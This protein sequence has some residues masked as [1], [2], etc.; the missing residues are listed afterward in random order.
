[1]VSIPSAANGTWSPFGRA[2]LAHAQMSSYDQWQWVHMQVGN[3]QIQS[4]HRF[5]GCTA[6]PQPAAHSGASS[7]RML[8]HSPWSFL[9]SLSGTDSWLKDI[10]AQKQG[11]S[12]KVDFFP[13]SFVYLLFEAMC[14]S[15]Y[16]ILGQKRCPE[17][18]QKC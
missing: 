18:R 11:L 5:L 6:V 16:H 4:D 13:K 7:K 2:I 1:M 17:S 9:G 8:A 12:I 14:L 15:T 10:L 3:A